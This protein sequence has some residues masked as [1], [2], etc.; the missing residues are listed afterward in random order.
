[1]AGD[2]DRGRPDGLR[3][4]WAAWGERSLRAVPSNTMRRALATPAPAYS[5]QGRPPKRPWQSVKT[6]AESLGPEAWRRVEVRDG[7]Q[8]PLGVDGVKRR[9][10]SSTHRR[11]QG[12]AELLAGIRSRARAQEQVVKGDDSLS[13]A[14]PQTRLAELA[15]V[16][17]AAQRSAAG[18]QRSKSAAG[19]ADDEGRHGTGWQQQHTLSFLA[20][21]FLVQETER[22]KKRDTGDDATPDAP[23]HR[24]DLAR[25]VSVRHDVPAAGC[26][27]EALATP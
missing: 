16:A 8:G 1:M 26:L 20:T 18:M 3:R 4:R 25:G 11:Q 12:D 5:G 10:V 27:P 17:K 9:G 2:D 7:A 13:N 22:G 19:W 14:A 21:W 15:R 6:W 23:R 24:G